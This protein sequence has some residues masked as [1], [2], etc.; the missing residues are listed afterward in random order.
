VAETADPVARDRLSGDL[1]AATEHLS[2]HLAHEE[3]EA[4]TLVQR[5]LT[6]AD[7]ERITAEHFVAPLSPRELLQVA[8]WLLHELPH[9]AVA[10]L[11]AEAK[12]PVLVAAWRLFL[13]R[14]FERRERR[15]FRYA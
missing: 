6:Q 2:A 3:G 4:M 1:A 10:R 9:A 13:R 7:W 5:H 14:P 15:A 12:G 8:A 11:R